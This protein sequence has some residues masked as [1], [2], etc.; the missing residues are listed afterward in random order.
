MGGKAKTLQP[1]VIPKSLG[2]IAEIQHCKHGKK[3]KAKGSKPAN[4][5]ILFHVNRGFKPYKITKQ[6]ILPSAL[7]P[8]FL[9]PRRSYFFGTN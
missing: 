4:C 8:I 5:D 6:I 9:A 3:K 7:M 1:T 2:H